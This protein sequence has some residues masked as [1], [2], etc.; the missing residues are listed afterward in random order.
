MKQFRRS[1]QRSVV[2]GGM[3][4]SLSGCGSAPTSNNAPST[5]APTA[6]PL[7][8]TS[9]SS[10]PSPSPSS[11]PS[12]S[13]KPPSAADTTPETAASKPADKDSATTTDKV[14]TQQ[15]AANSSQTQE[16]TV[17]QLDNQ[18]EEFVAKKVTVPTQDAA[19]TLVGKVLETSNSP[20][21]KIDN[22]RIQV[23]NGT[24]TIDLRLPPNAKRPFAA[25][26]ACEQRSLLGSLSKTLTEN[27][28]LKINAVRFTDG[29]EELQF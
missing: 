13:D 14:P 19:T 10:T 7:G 9:A 23:Q 6:S 22:Y 16:V 27:P 5:P 8:L 18:C 3:L 24:A 21:F 4:L 11:T 15:L 25:M 2:V 17:Y 29:K 12:P 1:V 26:S 20:D 28:K